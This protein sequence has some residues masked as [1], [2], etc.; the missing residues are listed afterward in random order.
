MS[1]K[2]IREDLTQIHWV[3]GKTEKL[4]RTNKFQFSVLW[5]TNKRTF[6]QCHKSQRFEM[7]VPAFQTFLDCRTPR[8][9]LE[10]KLKMIQKHLNNKIIVQKRSKN[11]S[12]EMMLTSI[13]RMITRSVWFLVWN[14]RNNF[15][16][17]KR[18]IFH[19]LFFRTTK[20]EKI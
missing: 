14:S 18:R 13:S 16:C 20:N 12:T 10:N 3:R 9:E 8:R 5:K 15:L 19:Y 2:H 7:C 1:Q 17:E 4:V 11:C 6:Q